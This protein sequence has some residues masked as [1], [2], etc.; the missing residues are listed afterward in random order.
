MTVGETTA[1]MNAE[2]TKLRSVRGTVVSLTLF[3]LVSIG[4][5]ALDGWSA[6]H[7]IATHSR[8][9]RSGFTPEQAGFDGILYGQVA[10]IAFG[11]L[12]VTSEYGSGMIRLSL[13]AVPRRGQFFLAK[14][15]VTALV[16]AVAAIPVTVVTYLVTQLALGHYG[17][18]IGAVGV[19]RALVGSVGYV[20]LMCLFAAALAVLTRNA[21]APL[22]VLIPLVLIGSHLLMLLGATKAFARYLPDQAGSQMLTVHVASGSLSPGAGLAVMAAWVA[23]AL[24]VGYVLQRMRDA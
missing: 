5:A 10:I 2:F 16:A 3:A 18:S 20:V 9:L 21:I 24:A 23:V 17:A 11:V 19:P 15:G 14:M 12:V 13:L 22:A 6:G 8:L 4:V 1:A 7:A